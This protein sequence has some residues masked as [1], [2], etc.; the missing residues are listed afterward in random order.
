[1][2]STLPIIFILLFQINLF[3]QKERIGYFGQPN[4]CYNA[5]SYSLYSD[6]TFQYFSLETNTFGSGIYSI[7]K[8]TVFLTFSGEEPTFTEKKDFKIEYIPKREVQVE[9][10]DMF[11]KK[12]VENYELIYQ[13][14]DGVSDTIESDTTG[15]CHLGQIFRPQKGKRS[16]ILEMKG[17]A[18]FSSFDP[19]TYAEIQTLTE[20]FQLK[21]KVNRSYGIKFVIY[22]DRR[23]K[24]KGNYFI[25]PANLQEK[26]LIYDKS[27]TLWKSSHLEGFGLKTGAAKRLKE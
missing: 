27:N 19:E 20:L 1:M 2:K 22:F 7:E 5:Y 4:R 23:K 15:I 12:A 6:R 26:V 10:I 8:D 3:A 24:E 25:V 14:N 17:T 9:V 21:F 11:S 16:C 18:N 13:I